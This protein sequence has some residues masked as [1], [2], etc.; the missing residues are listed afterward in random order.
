[1]TAAVGEAHLL[2]FGP[3][4][5]HR[6]GRAGK[7]ERR[8]DVFERGHCRNEMK[9]LEHDADALPAKPRQGVFVHRAELHAVDL[10]LASVRL[11]E[12][13]HGHQQ[14][15]FARAGGADEAPTASPLPIVRATSRKIC[16][17]AAPRPRL[18]VDVRAFRLLEQPL[19]KFPR[20]KPTSYGHWVRLVQAVALAAGSSSRLRPRRRGRFAR[21]PRRQ[22]DRRTGLPPARRFRIAC[23]QRSARGAGM[24]RSSMPACPAIRLLTGWRA[25]TGAC[26]RTPT[27]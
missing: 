22:P 19:P 11:L 1:M 26:R 6:V 24:S 27:R 7:L 14:R 8:R 25:M 18:E 17:R 12:P 23:R 4:S 2:E 13:G 3:G 16:T 9:G 20:A 21:G 15:R 5:L 10:D